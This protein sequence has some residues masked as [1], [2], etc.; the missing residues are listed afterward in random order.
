MYKDELDSDIIVVL[1]LDV[2]EASIVQRGNG[3][4]GHVSSV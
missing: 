2:K 1:R 4:A 3:K